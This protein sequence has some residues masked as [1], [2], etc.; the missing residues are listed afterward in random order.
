MRHVLRQLR[1]MRN[2]IAA[3]RLRRSG[4]IE[5]ED[6]EETE[7]VLADPISLPCGSLLVYYGRIRRETPSVS[8]GT[9][10]FRIKPSGILSNFI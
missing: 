9:L 3:R 10:K 5:Q 6:A 8:F 2:L 1:R 4:Q 7:K